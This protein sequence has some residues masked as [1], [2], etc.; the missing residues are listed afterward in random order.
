MGL[1]FEERHS[2]K[3]IIRS[4]KR[5]NEVPGW[6]KIGNANQHEDGIKS[7]SS[8]LSINQM[9]KVSCYSISF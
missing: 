5:L 9:F 4:V 7:W 3:G 2:G 1:V 6:S 8:W